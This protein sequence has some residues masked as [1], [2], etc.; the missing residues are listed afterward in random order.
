M[1]YYA[2]LN[3]ENMVE[4]VIAGIDETEMNGE[5]IYSQLYQKKCRRTSYNTYHG[6]HY[7]KETGQWSKARQ[8]R[9]NYAMPGFIYDEQRDAFI[10]PKPYDSWILNEEIC[11]WDPPIPEPEDG[12]SYEWNEPEQTWDLVEADQTA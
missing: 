2:L 3:D 4:S 9:M 10:P 11:D 8:F 5:L 7:S 1:A 12:N 6:R